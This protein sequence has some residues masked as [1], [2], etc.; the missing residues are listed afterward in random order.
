MKTVSFQGTQLTAGQR[1]SMA[2]QQ[3][4]RAAFLNPVLQQQVDQAMAEMDRRKAQ[5]LKAENPNKY[6][7]DYATKG[8]PW[9]GDVF[10]F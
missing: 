1:R 3:Q 10:G 4:T 2:F 6:T 8:T 7:L 5:G 9:L